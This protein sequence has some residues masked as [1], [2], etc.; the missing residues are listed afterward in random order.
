M[1][2]HCLYGVKVYCEFPLFDGAVP[3]SAV[4]PGEHS[5]LELRPLPATTKP[6]DYP[7][8]FPLSA[9]LHGPAG[10]LP[11]SPALPPGVED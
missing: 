2:E 11:L 3:V 5:P 7:E 8:T 9:E 10:H 6:R 4:A 1:I